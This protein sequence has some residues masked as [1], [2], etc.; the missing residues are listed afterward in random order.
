MMVVSQI[1]VHGLKFCG[2]CEFV[3]MDKRDTNGA[4]NIGKIS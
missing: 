4:I 2:Y 1:R 3:H